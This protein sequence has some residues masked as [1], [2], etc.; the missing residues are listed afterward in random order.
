[1]AINP[2]KLTVKTQETLQR[3]VELAGEHG[4]SQVEAEHLAL[5]CFEDSE[6]V[7][8][9]IIRKIGADDTTMRTKAEALVNK[10]PKV[11]GVASSQQYI[12]QSLNQVFDT[13]RREAE[14]LKDEY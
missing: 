2:S 7:V 6:G 5:A 4:N 3:A 11:T 9:A 1:M 13:A 12:S 8:V 10:L 14:G